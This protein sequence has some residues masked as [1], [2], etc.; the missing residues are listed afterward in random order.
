LS[1]SLRSRST[2]EGTGNVPRPGMVP[3]LPTRIPA[4]ASIAAERWVDM[5][6]A[7]PPVDEFLDPVIDGTVRA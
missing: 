5:T 4:G 2:A 7:T 3:V 1:I 6:R